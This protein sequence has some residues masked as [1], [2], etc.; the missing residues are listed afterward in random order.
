MV[1]CGHARCAKERCGLQLGV[2]LFDDH[3]N[4]ILSIMMKLFL[5][6]LKLYIIV[7]QIYINSVISSY[8]VGFMG[9]PLLK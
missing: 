7:T 9:A 8:T 2:L 1:R 4:I 6:N 3:V 5:F